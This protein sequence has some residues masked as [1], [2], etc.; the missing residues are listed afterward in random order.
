MSSTLEDGWMDG[1]MAGWVMGIGDMPPSDCW[2][3]IKIA[4]TRCR[5]L[6]VKDPN[7]ARILTQ[8]QW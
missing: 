8:G 2:E 4:L 7:P 6:A 1:W 5:L 3:V